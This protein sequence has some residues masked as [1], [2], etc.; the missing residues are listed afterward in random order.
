[1]APRGPFAPKVAAAACL[2]LGSLTLFEISRTRT[3]WLATGGGG[4]GGGGGGPVAAPREERGGLARN[5]TILLYG[6]NTLTRGL[7]R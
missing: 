4:G 2:A 7:F 5:K 6:S 1:M 3:A